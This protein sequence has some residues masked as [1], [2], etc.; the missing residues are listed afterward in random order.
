[1]TEKKLDFPDVFLYTEKMI[2]SMISREKKH[3]Y[4]NDHEKCYFR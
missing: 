2:K 3:V 1:M 4:E